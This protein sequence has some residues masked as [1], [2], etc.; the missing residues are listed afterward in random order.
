MSEFFQQVLFSIGNRDCTVG[1]LAL[2]GLVVLGFFVLYKL[3]LN[4]LLPQ[5]FAKAKIRIWKEESVSRIF[6]NIFI[7]ATLIGVTWSLD[8]DYVIY[9]AES[10][11]F[12]FRL[13]TLFEALL[14]FQIARLLDWIFSKIL[15]LNYYRSREILQGEKKPTIERPA[16][17]KKASR[18]VQYVVYVLAI[19]LILKSFRLESLFHFGAYSFTITSI[20]SALLVIL[21][22]RLL[23]WVLTQLILYAYY[24]KNQVNVG[25]QYAINQLLN[26]VIYVFAILMAMEIMGINMT[27]LWG[28]AAALLV[29]VGLGLQQTFNDLISG[30]I[31][32][33]EGKVEVGNVV[34]I[35]GGMIGT[36]RRIG[37][38]TSVVETLDN[39]TVVVPNSKLITENVVNWSYSDDKARFVVMVGVAYG[40]DTQLV[41]ELLLKVAKNNVYVLQ[42]PAPS[43]R[44]TDFGASSLDFQLIFWSRNFWIIEDIKSDL[45]FEIDR[46]F[47]ENNITIPFPQRD[48]WIRKEE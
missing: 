7:L 11:S 29:G 38:R 43:V 48:V 22:A 1:Q 47:R 6:R 33:F 13:T 12:V 28:G 34:M 42:S 37:L 9:S 21:I 25:S 35:N 10:L 31:L 15:L 3:V 36:V 44:F 20:F 4:W 27:V 19:I 41:R 45:R 8:L 23:T 14:I 32:L 24:Q 39:I 26:Y 17:E 40:S 16:I 2:A 46:V 30:I 18:T 5:Y